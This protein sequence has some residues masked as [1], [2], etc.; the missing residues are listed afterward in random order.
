M[1]GQVALDCK[2]E[3]D[4][5]DYVAS[6]RPELMEFAADWCLGARFMDIQKRSEFFEVTHLAQLHFLRLARCV[7]LE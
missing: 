1:F 2:M 7:P 4:V 3:I 5:D 6:F